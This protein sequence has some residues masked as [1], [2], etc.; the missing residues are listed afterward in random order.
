MD[1]LN[2]KMALA[3]CWAR[4]DNSMLMTDMGCTLIKRECL[5]KAWFLPD[6]NGEI[7]LNESNRFKDTFK[8]RVLKSGNSFIELFGVIGPIYHLD[9]K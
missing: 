7:S 6:P 8:A 3:N 5:E 9:N 2:S 1:K 4:Y